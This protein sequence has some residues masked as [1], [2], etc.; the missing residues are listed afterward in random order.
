MNEDA[1]RKEGRRSHTSMDRAFWRGE[2]SG[3]ALQPAL[4]IPVC[5]IHNVPMELDPPTRVEGNEL[6]GN[7]KCSE[8]KCGERKE[9]RA[10]VK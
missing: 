2:P 8:A 1:Y 6:V 5:P 7:Y 9:R 10:T 3:M 4:P